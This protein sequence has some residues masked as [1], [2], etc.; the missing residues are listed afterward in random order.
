[1]YN[2]MLTVFLLE[3]QFPVKLGVLNNKRMKDSLVTTIPRSKHQKVQLA[4]P[5]TRGFEGL[6]DPSCFSFFCRVILLSCVI[7]YSSSRP[8]M[9]SKGSKKIRSS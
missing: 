9:K 7:L 3:S 6:L 8:T 4:T 1:M 5:A 2:G